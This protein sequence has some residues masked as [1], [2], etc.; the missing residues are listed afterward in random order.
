MSVEFLSKSSPNKK[1]FHPSLKGPRKRAS[2]M[3]LKTWLLWK[4][5]AG[6]LS[7]GISF[8]VHSKGAFP[9]G[10]PLRVPSFRG[11]LFREPFFIHLSKSLVYDPP[12]MFPTG[13]LWREMP[14]SKAFLY[15]SFRVPVK[16]TSRFPS[17]SS[18]RERCCVFKALWGYC[19]NCR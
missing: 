1:T 3:F 15:I 6:F 12:S 16:E 17:Q 18:Y 4:Q 2:P 13:P 14:I 11:A 9:S 7:L 5:M 8:S 19:D 10:S